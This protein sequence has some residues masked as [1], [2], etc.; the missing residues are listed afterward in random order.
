[1]IRNYLAHHGI[2]GQKWGVRRYQ[3]PDGTLTT[4][5]KVRYSKYKEMGRPHTS[6]NLDKFGKSKDTNILFI[7]GVS[8]SG[9]SSMAKDIQK[10]MNTDLVLMD[11]Y[12]YSSGGKN[13]DQ[14]SKRFNRFLDK[15]VPNWKQMQKDAYDVLTKTDRR[16]EGKQAAGKW[17]D[18]F[19]DALLKYGRDSFPSKKIIAEG[20]QILDDTLFYNNKKALKGKPL[21]IMD[22]DKDT[23][24]M[25]RAIRDNKDVQKI[26]NNPEIMRQ[27]DIWY[28]GISELKNM[29]I[30]DLT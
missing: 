27:F 3:N 17:F 4:L 29:N 14:M 26:L 25:S 6:Y 24:V 16:G 20:V 19:E 5:G 7:T 1:M 10:N 21:I 9:K 28:N 22:T 23:S 12:L 30:E 18:T 15:N 8:G 2:Q 13:V 11:L